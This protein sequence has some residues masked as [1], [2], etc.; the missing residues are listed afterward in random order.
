M[1]R[2]FVSP[3]N[4]YAEALTP[5]GMVSVRSRHLVAG[6]HRGMSILWAGR[7]EHACLPPSAPRRRHVTPAICKL[8]ST[9]SSDTAPA[10]AFILDFQ[11]PELWELSICCL[12]PS[13]W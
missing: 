2:M 7:R 12:T 10:S 5:R 1:E 9:H 13:L 8:G 11:P 6:S 3:E 4:S